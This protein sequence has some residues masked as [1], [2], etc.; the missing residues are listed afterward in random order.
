MD[1][2]D[3][4]LEVGGVDDNIL[5]L[6]LSYSKVAKLIY[7][8]DIDDWRSPFI[9]NSTFAIELYFKS[10]LSTQKYIAGP[11]L[12]ETQTKM[13]YQKSTTDFSGQGHDLENLFEQIPD[14]KRQFL[15]KIFSQH[16]N[17]LDFTKFLKDHKKHFVNWR[18][19]FEGK[20][21]TFTPENI[22]TVLDVMY[23]YRIS[24]KGNPTKV[25]QV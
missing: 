15:L 6:A 7:E 24:I 2:S 19:C 12:S 9:V 8:S 1:I 11:K 22:I 3:F 14:D 5:N 21:E 18:Y 23:G 17:N 20:A 13:V 16:P 25:F 4:Y 10:M